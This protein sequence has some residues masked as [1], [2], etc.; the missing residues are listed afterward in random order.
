M[1]FCRIRVNR[2]PALPCPCWGGAERLEPQYRRRVAQPELMVPPKC[3]A[4]IVVWRIAQAKPVHLEPEREKSPTG[5]A[6]KPNAAAEKIE[7]HPRARPSAKHTHRH[8]PT[9][10]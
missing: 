6:Q 3:R 4:K 5:V 9:Q 7:E 2:S 10:A 8:W 1:N